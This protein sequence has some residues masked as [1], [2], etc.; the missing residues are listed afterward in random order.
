MIKRWE[1]AVTLM[2]FRSKV[3]PQIT[4]TDGEKLA[5]ATDVFSFPAAKRAE[6]QR[7]LVAL[8]GVE[9]PDGEDPRYVFPGG[10]G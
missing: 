4:N 6:V 5:Q 8:D 3:P 9:E 2:D 10:A 1:E 7:R